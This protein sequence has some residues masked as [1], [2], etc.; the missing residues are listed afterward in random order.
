MDLTF[1]YCNKLRVA[2]AFTFS[3]KWRFFFA[4]CNFPRCVLFALV[5]A[6]ESLI[7]DDELQVCTNVYP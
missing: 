4:D 7:N 6:V 5:N 1:A 2:F 3:R